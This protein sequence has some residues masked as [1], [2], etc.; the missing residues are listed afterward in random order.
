MDYNTLRS[1]QLN[2]QVSQAAAEEVTFAPLSKPEIAH[3]KA[4]TKYPEFLALCAILEAQKKNVV[5]AHFN[6]S[7]MGNT[8]DIDRFKHG[9]KRGM[10]DAYDYI[11]NLSKKFVD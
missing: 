11:I 9:F 8:E 4:L 1:T 3:L 5:Q 6:E 2:K 7:F 10:Y